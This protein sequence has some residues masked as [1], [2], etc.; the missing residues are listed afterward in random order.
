MGLALHEVKVGSQSLFCIDKRFIFRIIKHTILTKLFLSE[1]GGGWRRSVFGR[2]KRSS[3]LL[4]G[5]YWKQG[6]KWSFQKVRIQTLKE[7]N[8]QS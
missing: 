5:V 6:V 8:M 7:C 3:V 2:R 4:Q 1:R